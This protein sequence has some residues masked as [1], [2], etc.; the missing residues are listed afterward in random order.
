MSTWREGEG[1]GEGQGDSAGARTQ[2]NKRGRRE[3]GCLPRFIVEVR[4]TWLLQGNC[5]GGV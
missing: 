1:K 2:E 5:G 3:G 4:P